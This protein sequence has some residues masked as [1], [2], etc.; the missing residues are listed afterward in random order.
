MT[1]Q[2]QNERP[3]T[4]ALSGPLGAVVAGLAAG[5][6][7]V[8]GTI[9][10]LGACRVIRGT[11]N[12]GGTFGLIGMLIIGAAAIA[13]GAVLLARFGAVYTVGT[14]TFA[15]LVVACLSLLFFAELLLSWSAALLIPLLC[16]VVFAGS[17]WLTNVALIAADE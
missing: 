5:A 14:S 7:M 3:L 6:V 17:H 8:L 11:A 1:E 16:A 15:V 12:C 13:V 2:E 4:A 10:G 9:A